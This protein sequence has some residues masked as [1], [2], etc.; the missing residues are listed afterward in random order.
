MGKKDKKKG[1][2]LQDA[3]VLD[4]RRC[5]YLRAIQSKRV[6]ILVGPA[7]QQFLVAQDLLVHYSPA[8]QKVC[9]SSSKEAYTGTAAAQNITEL[10]R[11][12]DFISAMNRHGELGVDV[13]ELVLR[14]KAEEAIFP[15]EDIPSE[16]HLPCLKP[17]PRHPR[18]TKT[19][20]LRGW[21]TG[22]YAEIANTKCGHM[23]GFEDIIAEFAPEFCGLKDL[24]EE[25]KNVLFPIKGKMLIGTYKDRSIMYDGM[26][27]AF[28]NLKKEQ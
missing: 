4:L 23:V 17:R 7:K 26:I 16:K 6:T 22:T 21:Y 9:Q 24:A 2:Q 27:N 1:R 13:L 25:L 12:P 18:S 15:L 10:M 5:W 19:S 20:I 14:E 3:G 8:F 28:N 11:I